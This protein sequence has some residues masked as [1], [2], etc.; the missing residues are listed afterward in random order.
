[1]KICDW[2][3]VD[4]DVEGW[5]SFFQVLSDLSRDLVSLGKEL[6]RTVLGDYSLEYFIDKGR[7]DL[8]KGEFYLLIKV[9]SKRSVDLD[10]LIRFWSEKDSDS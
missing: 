8:N 5:G 4:K 2:D 6:V 3:I 7:K 10:K 1:M 9:E